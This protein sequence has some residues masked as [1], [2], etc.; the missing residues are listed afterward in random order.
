MKP[1][2]P[3]EPATSEEQQRFEKFARALMAVPK[4]ELD[5]EMA[6]E[7]ARKKKTKKN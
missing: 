7:D 1:T 5:R 6:K 2:K 4:K 3:K